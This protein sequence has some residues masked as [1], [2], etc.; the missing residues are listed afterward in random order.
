M[1]GEHSSP[2]QTRLKPQQ[3]AAASRRKP[4]H[5]IPTLLK[6]VFVGASIGTVG[7]LIQSA[8]ARICL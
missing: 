4:S 3:Q 6:F 7:G 1:F 5:S 8:H 2:L